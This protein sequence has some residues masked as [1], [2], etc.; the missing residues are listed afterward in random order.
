V[1]LA[2]GPPS[3]TLPNAK[4]VT[5]RLF[6]LLVVKLLGLAIMAGGAMLVAYRFVPEIP[7]FRYRFTEL[8]SAE[9][10][11]IDVLILIPLGALI[12][13]AGFFTLI[14]R[15]P[16]KGKRGHITFRGAHGDVKIDLDS[17]ENNIHKAV[18]KMPEIKKI[19]LKVFPTANGSSVQIIGDVVLYKEAGVGALATSNFVRESVEMTAQ[20]ILGVN[21][22][23]S[24]ELNVR[25][26]VQKRGATEKEAELVGRRRDVTHAQLPGHG[27]IAPSARLTH[28]PVESRH[29]T[30]HDTAQDHS[31]DHGHDHSRDDEPSSGAPAAGEHGDTPHDAEKDERP[32]S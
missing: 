1:P 15:L 21:E 32:S 16:A 5:M 12:F 11:P 25:D 6:Q 9:N 19:D 2:D 14:P 23:T 30:S 10:S 4:E 28:E 3:H 17:I 8:V 18:S 7:A 27:A 20:S 29:E 26:V 31:H 13:I 22:V 24:V